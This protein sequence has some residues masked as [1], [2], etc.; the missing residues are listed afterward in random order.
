VEMYAL[1]SMSIAD[2]FIGC[3]KEKYR[4]NVVRPVTY[5]QR[6]FDKRFQTVFPTPPFPEYTSGHS[7]QSAAAVAVLERLVGSNVSFIDST[8]VDVGQ[9]A[10]PFASFRAARDEVAISRLYGGVH[11]LPAIVDGVAQGE[12]IARRVLQ[13]RTRKGP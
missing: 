1:M 13:L 12:C 11:Y 2:A 10:R 5:V 7:V 6:V 3:W 4:S 9:P 8:Q